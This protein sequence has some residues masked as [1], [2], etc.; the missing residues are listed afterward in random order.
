MRL[1]GWN[2]VPEGYGASFDVAAAPWWLRALYGTPL[3]DR[4][5]YPLLVR[6]GHGCLRASPSPPP[7]GRGEVAGGWRVA[8]PDSDGAG[9]AVWLTRDP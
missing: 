9:R 2:H 6:R 1:E 4:F 3:L 8:P 5:A 7:G